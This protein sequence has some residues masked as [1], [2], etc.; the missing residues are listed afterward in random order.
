[1]DSKERELRRRLKNDFP[2]YAEKCLKIRTKGGGIFPLRLNTAQL[3]IHAALE[4]QRKMTGK[5][6]AIVLKGRQQGCSTYVEA[7]FYWKVTHQKGAQ[8][9]ILTHLE[10][11]SRNIYQIARRFHDYCPLSVKPR[12][13][14][15][16]ARELVFNLLD[17]G[18][19]V[20]TARSS[21]VGRSN[22]LQYFH[23]SEVAYWPNADDHI[24][25][26][27][28]A[29]AEA[30]G[31]EV[32]LESTSSGP[33]GLFYELSQSA[34]AGESEYRFIFVPWY[35]QEEYRRTPP[36]HFI[37]T[38]EETFTADSFAL[39][40]AQIFWRRCK[41]H[42]LG[43]LHAFRRE[44][45]CTPE[46]AFT[47]DHP[48]A[49][50][51][52]HMLSKNRIPS[53]SCPDMR[54]IVVAID[55]AAGSSQNNAE[56]GIVVAGIG[57]DNHGYVLA[58]VSGRYSPAQWAAK[59]VEAFYTFQADRIIAE[60]NQGGDMVEYTLRA[61][62]PDIPY[63]A[64][65][66]SRGKIARAEPIAALDEQGRIHHVGIFPALEDQMCGFISDGEGS[67]PDR[68]DARIWALTEL[69]L[70]QSPS[71]GPKIWR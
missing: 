18:Y 65:R 16:N 57:M 9:F 1:M 47:A 41:I 50:W 4:A 59:A 31:T 52:R 44:Y 2:F 13:S 56:T 49:L 35:W 69:M 11:A 63:K 30:D 26:I 61:A 43:G 33:G 28:Q 70:G 21:G 5:V 36:Q 24:S 20:G 32:I 60:V 8:A 40:Q 62:C 14:H 10:E 27:L 66:A 51:T 6:R 67:S 12:T 58:D 68:M 17:S 37:P 7:R 71:A 45:P 22:T 39:D 38:D 64:V 54:R 55:P 3:H 46:E 29:V 25:G 42:E 19:Q 15:S 34:I 48:G 23:G 53:A